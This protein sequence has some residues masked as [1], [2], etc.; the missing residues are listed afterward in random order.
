METMEFYLNAGDKGGACPPGSSDMKDKYTPG[1]Q[2]KA[3]QGGQ[4]GQSGYGQAG[5]QSNTT[6]AA[7]QEQQMPAGQYG[8]GGAAG[9]T[10]QQYTPDD[11]DTGAAPDKGKD[12]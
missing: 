3:Q 6:G 2:D 5:Y 10:G 7:Q 8:Q 4:T 12:K 9:K 11:G 1:S